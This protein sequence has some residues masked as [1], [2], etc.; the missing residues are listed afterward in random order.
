MFKLATVP[1]EALE[2]LPG[3]RVD[4]EMGDDLVCV[5]PVGELDL[6][7]RG[8]LL[9]QL[10]YL[11]DAGFQRVTLDLR[12]LEFIDCSGLHVILDAD[13]RARAEGADF[14]VIPGSPAVRRLFELTGTDRHLRFRCQ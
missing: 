14:G 2:D 10:E 6:A 8:R 4:V 7:S 5:V 1:E 12:Q 13:A 11:Q 9:E 3:F